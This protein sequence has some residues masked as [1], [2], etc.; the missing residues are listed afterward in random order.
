MITIEQYN[1]G[2]KAE[3]D[4]LVRRSRNATFLHERAYM[5]YHSDRFADCSLMARDDAGR[6]LTVLPANREDA[7]LCSHRGLSYGGWLMPAKRVDAVVMLEVVQASVEWMKAHGIKEFVYKPVPHIYH[8]Y[9]AEE[10]IYA[11]WRA[12][13]RLTETSVSTTID[14]T[15]PLPLDRGNKSGL[16]MAQRA[17]VAVGKSDQWEAYWRLLTDVLAER[18]EARPVH[19]IDEMRL[20][21]SRFPDHIELYA[22]TAGGRLLAGVVV[23]FTGTVA[24]SQ[25]IAASAEGRDCHALTMLF[26]HL[27]GEAIARGC[28]YLDFGISTEEH[29]RVLNHGLVQ[30]KS[31]LGGRA[32]V[33]QVMALDI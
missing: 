30:Q 12:G 4:D 10:D 26:E 1:A 18:H 21:H 25:Y 24:H 23:Y 31:R 16:R 7:V 6:L 15:D 20:L 2:L 3:W 9:P 14:L 33:T 22:A 13:A 5:D 17:G 8:R 32:T 27:K 19:C 28:R 29:G 11:L